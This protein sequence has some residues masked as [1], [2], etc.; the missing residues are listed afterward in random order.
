LPLSF[1]CSILDLVRASPFVPKDLRRRLEVAR[2]DT[3]ALLRAADQASIDPHLLEPELNQLYELDADCAEALWALD[4]P[5][6][7]LDFKAMVTDT[8]ASLDKLAGT[9]DR[10][11]KQLPKRDMSRVITLETGIRINLHPYEAY[12]GLD[13]HDPHFR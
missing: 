5:P 7:A 11:R 10:L 6:H 1:P 13:D 9:R 12:N 8:L 2:L 4:Q 3:L